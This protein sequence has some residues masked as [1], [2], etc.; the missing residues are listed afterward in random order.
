MPTLSRAL[1]RLRGAVG[2]AARPPPPGGVRC[3]CSATWTAGHRAPSYSIGD[4]GAG[5]EPPALPTET[6]VTRH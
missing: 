4:G 3:A 6:R 5:D 1:W 2:R